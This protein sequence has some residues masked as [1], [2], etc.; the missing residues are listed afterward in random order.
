[1]KRE[2]IK[3]ADVAVY[4]GLWGKYEISV[5]HDSC[6]GARK[7]TAVI[8]RIV[9]E[10]AGRSM[11]RS[12]EECPEY[13]SGECTLKYIE[14]ENLRITTGV[15]RMPKYGSKVSGDSFS[16]M[17]GNSGKYTL[18]L[19]DGMGTGHGASIQSKAAVD[20]LESFLESGFDKDT[21]VDLINSV[22]VLK[23]DGDSTCTMDIAMIDLFSGEVEFIKIGAAPTYIKRDSRVEMIRSAS[24]PAGILPGV[25]AELSRKY[26]DAGD[27]II[28]VTDGI[29]GSMADDEQGDRVLLKYIRQMESLNPQLVAESILEEAVGRCGGQ[30]SD[31]MTVLVAKVWKKPL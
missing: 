21:A 30:P 15:A 12:D 8:D 3:A 20:M 28:M 13:G 16:F 29:T 2:G 18:A 7:C 6:G 10:A 22:L 31:D 14:A 19:S 1:L 27:M 25:D 17:D 5:R 11:V 24:L 4:K 26:M 23:S 9:S